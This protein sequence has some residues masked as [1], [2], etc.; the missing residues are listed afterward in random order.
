MQTLPAPREVVLE[1]LE[2]ML[3][4]DTFAGAERSRALLK[5]L[6][7]QSLENQSDRLKEYTIGSEALGRGDSFDPRTDPIVR[8]EASRLRGRIER[9]YATS[10][11]SDTLL[12]T[13]PKGSYVP[14]FQRRT[15]PDTASV[16]ATAGSRLSAAGR[17]QRFIWFILGGL[18]VGAALTLFVW[19]RG[20]PSSSEFEIIDYELG[21]A[22]HSLGS[23]WGNDIVLSPNG[24][25]IVFVARGPDHV[26]RLMTV[27]VS[28]PRTVVAL[29][30]TDG[31]RAPF[32]SPDGS[33]VGFW[34][35][36]KLKKISID[37]GSPTELTEAIVFRGAS[38]GKDGYIVAA[39]DNGLKRVS[40]ASGESIPVLDL[41][42][43]RVAPWWPDILPGGTHV[44]FTAVGPRG[45]DA[46]SIEMVSLS[47]ER[48]R[49]PLIAKGTFGRYL[50]DGYLLY[51]NQ[52]T[53][54]AVPFDQR[55]LTV[56]GA[57]IPVLDERIAYNAVFGD[58]KLD[59]SRN[60]R[61][62]YRRSTPLVVSW[63]PRSGG[64][65]PLLTRPG[66][67]AFPRLSPDRRRLAINVTDSGV[68]RT[69]VYDILDKAQKQTRLP[70]TPG[71]I[72]PVWHRSG[73]LV[74]G[75]RDAGMSWMKTDDMTD[76][77]VKDDTPKVH[78]LTRS[79]NVQ[80]PWSF[81]PDGTRLAY[82]EESASS[83][84][85]LWTIRVTTSG[86]ELSTDGTPELFLETPF[87]E[88][89]PSFSHDGGWL[90]YGWGKSGIWEVWVGRFP[91]DGSPPVKV[92]QQGGRIPR[93]LPGGRELLY[94]TD[95]G[96][97]MVVA[98]QVKNGNF[99]ADAPKEWTPVRLADTNLIDNFDVS[100]DGVLG[101]VPAEKEAERDRNRATM[102]PRFLDEVRRRFSQGGK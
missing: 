25:R 100:G 74:V 56:Q 79:S 90:A 5:F 67:Y 81:T 95:D 54:F 15:V 17:F 38:W 53:L 8:A 6:V 48:E 37:G 3:A 65:E 13:L 46:S 7:E 50:G 9:Y 31:A 82:F 63:L 72:S 62:I 93:W 2:R 85:D 97:L 69:D 80:I 12:I 61:L 43:E 88:S 34:A 36:A 94:R 1:Q 49:T 39:I 87:I 23:D 68:V 70:F 18:T 32:F 102:R 4:S 89:A 33:R 64:V 60:G 86:G 73:F 21:T 10:G 30:D 41:S 98:F 59:V 22:D 58:A 40:E 24:T 92:S 99:I 35:D 11:A 96:R 14:Q 91:R 29:P 27:N 28:Q 57:A 44:M 52:G 66:P 45:P 75:S 76:E 51:V 84:L 19:V 20:E 77:T 83:A 55:K 26:Q 42:K 47:N 16:A 78:P 101:L 71:N